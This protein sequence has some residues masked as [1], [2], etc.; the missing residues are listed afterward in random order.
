[1]ARLFS[2]LVRSF[3]ISLAADAP[4]TV[5]GTL[6]SFVVGHSQDSRGTLADPKSPVWKNAKSTSIV[7]D[8]AKSSIIQR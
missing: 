2:F 3:S 1:M 7:K 8:C 4:C 5:N 6:A